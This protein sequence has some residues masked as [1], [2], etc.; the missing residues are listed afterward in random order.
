MAGG[1]SQDRQVTARSLAGSS[2]AAFSWSSKRS[3]RSDPKDRS[4]PHKRP[5]GVVSLEVLY[6][7]I[8]PDLTRLAEIS[9]GGQFAAANGPVPEPFPPAAGSAWA[10]GELDA[11]SGVLVDEPSAP[12]GRHGRA[13][14][15]RALIDIHSMNGEH[16]SVSQTR[17]GW[18]FSAGV[19]RVGSGNC[20]PSHRVLA[21]GLGIDASAAWILSSNVRNLMHQE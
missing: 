21:S 8:A 16:S 12:F 20:R 9:F 10:G 13:R 17:A 14:L 15:P 2:G 4:R 11:G 6:R 1:T 19:W 7:P 18:L 5:A 3:A